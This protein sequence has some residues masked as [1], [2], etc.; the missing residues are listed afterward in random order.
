MRR[1]QLAGS[2]GLTNVVRHAYRG[3]PVGRIELVAAVA[4]D[5]LWVLISDNGHGVKPR[6]DSPGLGLGLAL[7]AAIS[8]GMEI[9]SRSSG[10][11]EL[12]MRFSLRPTEVADDQLRGSDDSA[13]A[14][15]AS[16]FSTTV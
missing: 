9:V 4:A 11:T 2:E 6:A 8:D 16:S 5:E 10:G 1:S 12:R 15:A 7:I 13:A 14:P 3:R